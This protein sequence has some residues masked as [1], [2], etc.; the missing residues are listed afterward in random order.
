MPNFAPLV[1]ALLDSILLFTGCQQLS[2]RWK[3]HRKFSHL[4]IVKENVVNKRK[5][6]YRIT[7]NFLL[8][9]KTLQSLSWLLWQGWDDYDLKTHIKLWIFWM[10]YG[11]ILSVSLLIKGDFASVVVGINRN[12]KKNGKKRSL[13]RALLMG[14]AV[15]ATIICMWGCA[16]SIGVQETP[17]WQYTGLVISILNGFITYKM[18]K[19]IISTTRETQ[20]STMHVRAS[21]T[22][23]E[24]ERQLV[25]LF[26]MKA[27]VVAL[28]CIGL[29]AIY[30]FISNVFLIVDQ[31]I[32]YQPFIG[33][34][35][36]YL[37]SKLVTYN[38]YIYSMVAIVF[39]YTWISYAGIREAAIKAKRKDT[40]TTPNDPEN[41]IVIMPDTLEIEYPPHIDPNDPDNRMDNES[42]PYNSRHT[43]RHNSRRNSMNRH[44]QINLQPILTC[45]NNG[46]GIPNNHPSPI[47]SHSSPPTPN[48]EEMHMNHHGLNGRHNW[49]NPMSP[50]SKFSV[51]S[52]TATATHF[53]DVNVINHIPSKVAPSDV[54]RKASYQQHLD[55]EEPQNIFP[56][57]GHKI[58]I[59][60]Y[61]D[62]SSLNIEHFIRESKKVRPQTTMFD[63]DIVALKKR[64]ASLESKCKDIYVLYVYTL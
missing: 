11:V 58:S 30:A 55:A 17:I 23:K 22:P 28:F 42:E 13:W 33:N 6:I 2:F 32:I 43:S 60:H 49:N 51:M 34:E 3:V 64:G 50:E 36:W 29:N 10:Y 24:F 18:T 19:S 45:N 1:I 9:I 53:D 47:S 25:T 31:K 56:I 41:D 35:S 15:L 39:I 40:L 12:I 5:D 20:E 59:G 38:L 26:N 37:Y 14:S 46:R 16:L 52:N 27:M 57:F 8:L 7:V 54:M 48:F 4:E 62:N 21:I 44:V 63:L 61:A